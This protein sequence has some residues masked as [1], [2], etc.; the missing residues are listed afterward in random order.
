MSRTASLSF[1]RPLALLLGLLVLL[2]VTPSTD[3]LFSKLAKKKK[4]VQEQQLE[5]FTGTQSADMGLEAFQ[6]LCTY[7][8]MM[9]E[10]GDVPCHMIDLDV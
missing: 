4:P 10:E 6:D 5:E 8:M 9:V 7:L 1:L 2:L 3:A